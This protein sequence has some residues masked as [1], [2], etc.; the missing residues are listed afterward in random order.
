VLAKGG[1][2]FDAAIA[3]SATLAVTEP[4]GSG[5]GGGGF[6]L[7]H[8]ASDGLDTMIDG[9]ERAPLAAT[10]N[11]YLDNNGNPIPHASLDGPLAAGI[12]GVP[13]AL[14]YMAHHYGRLPLKQSL[15]PAIRIARDGFPV[16]ERFRRLAN[17]RK[18]I[19]KG[20]DASKVFLDHGK[21][22]TVGFI[23][24]QPDLAKTLQR[25]ADRGR[26]G[27]YRGTI[28]RRMVRA[29]RKAGGIWTRKDL[30]EYRV[31]ERKPVTIRYHNSMIV[32]ASLPS[33]GGIVLA[34]TFNILEGLPLTT[35]SP[36]ERKRLIIE[37]MRRGYN[38]RARFLGDSDFV[39]VDQ[40]LLTS[41]AYAAKRRKT[42]G[43]RATPSSSLPAPGSTAH[44]R[45]TDTTHF[46][47]I[48]ADGN[49]VSAT[50]SINYPFGC[51]FMPP[52]TGV[53]L[54]N[55]MDDFVIKPGVGNVYGLV[56]AHANQIAPG[57]RPLSSMSPSFVEKGD[58]V[59][60][61]GTPG[62]SRIISM[63]LLGSLEFLE[64]RGKP[65]DWVA[66]PRYHHQYIPDV[67]QYEEGAF[68]AIDRD[69]LEGLGYH[70]K[71]VGRR[72]GNMQVVLLN[73]RSGKLQAASDPRGE[74]LAAVREMQH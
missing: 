65:A 57:K 9:R 1:N 7:L 51:G 69:T 25:I 34:E 14:V 17:F 62:G 23:V 38:D 36:L 50:L 32:S 55:E 72:Y 28:A 39:S 40:K 52:G 42:I 20:S 11:M 70:F 56:G 12:P 5:L 53:V 54:N 68:D 10:A 47:I 67:V 27:F 63:V 19:F 37:A 4:M 6:W 13:A 15:A 44:P 71:N 35:V 16:Y 60:V 18:D 24:K 33:S 59:L 64:G 26:D 2:A 73:R 43:K 49:R 74:G 41:K 22:P 3:V 30:D 48:D 21:V 61:I 46:S 66:L 45:G 8:R 29:V 31:V 58:Q